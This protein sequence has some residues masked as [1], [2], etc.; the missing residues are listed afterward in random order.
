[1]IAKKNAVRL[2]HFYLKKLTNLSE[3]ECILN[4]KNA[5]IEMAKELPMLGVQARDFCY[6]LIPA[7]TPLNTTKPM[8]TIAIIGNDS[9]SHNTPYKVDSTTAK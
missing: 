2:R 7:N 4:I 1:M 3:S 9:S 8:P 6:F 5:Y